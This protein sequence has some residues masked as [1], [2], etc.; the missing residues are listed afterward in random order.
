MASAARSFLDGNHHIRPQ[1]MNDLSAKS[2]RGSTWAPRPALAAGLAALA[3]G[4][5]LS[6]CADVRRASFLPPVNPESP[7]AAQVAIGARRNFTTPAFTNVPPSPRNVPPA[8]AVK[9]AVFTMVGCR[10]SF[11]RWTRQNP[12]MVSDTTGFATLEQAKVD[13][14]PADVPTKAQDQASQTLADQMKAY[15]SPPAA[16]PSGPAPS[17]SEL[18]APPPKAATPAPPAAASAPA[19]T[20]KPA[21][22]AKAPSTKANS[23]KPA[24][25]KTASA[26]STPT[27]VEPAAASAASAGSARP[28][29]P[30]AS[31]AAV[32]V[33]APGLAL[34]PPPVA[35]ATDPLLQHC[36]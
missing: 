10:R 6:G 26:K 17:A 16:L 28:A 29:A 33:Q 21:P 18:V 32:T 36:Q 31:V 24:S 13:T 34:A 12:A 15:A 1:V 11:E 5:S 4:T 25:T 7:V 27:K 35:A 14:D 23:T 8:P 30:V 19:A 9:S 22:K 3:M 20:A 2:M